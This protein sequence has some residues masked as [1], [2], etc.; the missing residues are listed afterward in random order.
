[1]ESEQVNIARKAREDPFTSYHPDNDDLVK[2]VNALY[3]NVEAAPTGY[4]GATGSPKKMKGKWLLRSRNDFSIPYFDP[5]QQMPSTSGYAAIYVDKNGFLQSIFLVDTENE[6]DIRGTIYGLTKNVFEQ[7]LLSWP[8]RG[9]N[10]ERAKTWAQNLTLG[11]VSALAAG[12]IIYTLANGHE[13]ASWS[14]EQKQLYLSIAGGAGALT[15]VAGFTYMASLAKKHGKAA[16]MYRIRN[17]P[18]AA[19]NFLYGNDAA[20][21]V[22]HEYDTLVTEKQKALLRDELLKMGIR[23]PNDTIVGLHG[24]LKRIEKPIDVVPVVKR[25]EGRTSPAIPLE[26]ILNLGH[27][28]KISKA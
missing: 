8:P 7:P 5:N 1:M 23:L 4:P 22:E 28:L 19:S 9:L 18:E 2:G 20:E 3:Q 13:M 16:D 6:H 21:R 24:D 26:Q 15:T 14:D 11:S 25:L 27:A 17:L 12:L 10:E